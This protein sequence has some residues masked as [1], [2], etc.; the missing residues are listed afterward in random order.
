MTSALA[1]VDHVGVRLAL[2][3]L[4]IRADR[5]WPSRLVL[6]RTVAAEPDEQGRVEQLWISALLTIEQARETL[7]ALFDG[8]AADLVRG[9]PVGALPGLAEASGAELD[10]LEAEFGEPAGAALLVACSARAAGGIRSGRLLAAEVVGG[11]GR[12]AH[13]ARF[14]LADTL[15]RLGLVACGG[16]TEASADAGAGGGAAATEAPDLSPALQVDAVARESAAARTR[17]TQVERWDEFSRAHVSVSPMGTE[18]PDDG[19]RWMRIDRQVPAEASP[20][21]SDPKSV[22]VTFIDVTGGVVGP[23]ARQTNL[24]RYRVSPRVDLE[25]A[26]RSDS[27]R[28]AFAEYSTYAAGKDADPAECAKLREK[29]VDS[30][31]HAL[32]HGETTWQAGERPVG[33][34]PKATSETVETLSGTVVL[35]DCRNIQVGN[36]VRQFNTFS[37]ALAPQVKA[38]SLLEENPALAESIVD[39]ACVADGPGRAAVQQELADAVCNSAEAALPR[40]KGSGMHSQTRVTVR[41]QVG[42]IAGCHGR[43]SDIYA[44][45]VEGKLNRVSSEL[46]RVHQQVA[47][48]KR[49][50][51]QRIRQDRRAELRR[52]VEVAEP[53]SVEAV[54]LA[55]QRVALPTQVRHL[56]GPSIGL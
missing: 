17:L 46:Q 15:A 11:T 54:H 53:S 50:E 40:E 42:Q 13:R 9:R 55:P 2:H 3:G 18:A 8:P 34:E 23:N 12:A 39:Y 5:I 41:G 22:V 48:R 27:V 25:R 44:V 49:V 28:T 16:S 19:P 56:P 52:S 37:Y 47:A 51:I 26:L 43:Q 21:T 45:R 6:C 33:A 32:P 29:A 36:D 35:Q 7:N 1:A 14:R 24:F 31:R 4:G 20:P 10:A 30:L 38:G